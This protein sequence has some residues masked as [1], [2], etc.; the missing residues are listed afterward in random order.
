MIQQMSEQMLH[1]VQRYNISQRKAIHEK[2]FHQMIQHHK[3]INY[4]LIANYLQD[5]ILNEIKSSKLKNHYF[6]FA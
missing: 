5:L 1:K 3:K 4:V 2:K 6:S